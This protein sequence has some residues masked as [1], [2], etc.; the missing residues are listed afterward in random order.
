MTDRGEIFMVVPPVEVSHIESKLTGAR[1]IITFAWIQLTAAGTIIWPEGAEDPAQGR[2]HVEARLR[3]I[4]WDM[5]DCEYELA[6]GLLENSE[7]RLRTA[8]QTQEAF[9]Q[10]RDERDLD[11]T[12]VLPQP[13]PARSAVQTTVVATQSQS[14]QTRETAFP[15]Y[16]DEWAYNPYMGWKPDDVLVFLYI[17]TNPCASAR[18]Q[19]YDVPPQLFRRPPPCRPC[20]YLHLPFL[21]PGPLFPCPLPFLYQRHQALARFQWS[22]PLGPAPPPQRPRHRNSSLYHVVL[23]LLGL[24]APLL[25]LRALQL[26]EWLHQEA[27]HCLGTSLRLHYGAGHSDQVRCR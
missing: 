8:Y 17:S 18:L 9:D 5:S 19:G 23:P 13:K 11:R 25:G 1:V 7:N 6:D 10:A 3:D 27:Y 20:L 14:V 16:R 22:P 12:H 2:P 4:A 24:R 15:A 26:K 21:R